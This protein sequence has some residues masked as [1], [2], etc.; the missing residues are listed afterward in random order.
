MAQRR[1]DPTDQD[2]LALMKFYNRQLQS[3]ARILQMARGQRGQLLPG[4][5]VRPVQQGAGYRTGPSS[6]PA[7]SAI[8]AAT[9]TPA[10]GRSGPPPVPDYI[11]NID[12]FNVE[13]LT[14]IATNAFKD[15]VLTD[16]RQESYVHADIQLTGNAYPRS[17]NT[18]M[19]LWSGARATGVTLETGQWDLAD[20]YVFLPGGRISATA[21]FMTEDY[22]YSVYPS[23]LLTPVDGTVPAPG[24]HLTLGVY[25]YVEERT[26]KL[27]LYMNGVRVIKGAAGEVVDLPV[28]IQGKD[29][30]LYYWTEPLGGEANIMAW[31]AMST[32]LAAGGNWNATIMATYG[33]RK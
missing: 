12:D 30:L 15:V 2:R 27:D 18:S 9:A 4:I 31:D 10:G 33:I 22:A 25:A 28:T 6:G 1:E 32:S 7:T 13:T 17:H 21:A 11:V 14:A 16:A 29:Y 3:Q 20:T 5:G 26:P 23:L 19:Q 8:I 24:G